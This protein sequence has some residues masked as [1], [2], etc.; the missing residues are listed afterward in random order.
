MLKAGIV[1]KFLKFDPT[2]STFQKTPMN[3]GVKLLMSAI[4]A[5]I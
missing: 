3:S 1:L 4:I 2:L 5:T